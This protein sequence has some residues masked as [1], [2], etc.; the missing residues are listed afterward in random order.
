MSATLCKHR[1]K[2][3][4]LGFNPIIAKSVVLLGIVVGTGTVG[5]IWIEGWS[6]WQSLFFTLITLSTVGYGDNGLSEAGERF[7]AVLMIGGIGTV[8]YTA[9]SLLN[10]AV[11]RAAHPER[12][13]MQRIKHL[14]DHHVVCGLGRTGERVIERLR[15][16]NVEV[17]A[18]DTNSRAVEKMRTRGVMA[19]E[20][21]A[22]LDDTLA[23][24]GVD[25]AC[26]IAVVT[27][28]DAVNALIC[29][30]AR[31]L[32][33]ETTIIA[34]AEDETSVRK[35][36]R[37]GATNVIAPASYGGDGVAQYMLHP[38]VNHLLRG[39]QTEGAAIDFS[40]IFVSQESPHCGRTIEEI[41]GDNPRLVFVAARGRDQLVI[42]RPD[43]MRPLEDGDVLVV[44]GIPED[45]RALRAFKR[46]A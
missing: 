18:I 40:E 14:R 25:R 31:A 46:A 15:E 17:V 34:R 33:P 24:A 38:Q 45:V 23:K 22:S 43:P 11:A 20:G 27:S 1:P 30:T 6:A 41:G 12:R 21:D 32:T 13:I 36:Q 8:S 5:Y 44:A 16:E 10:R 3:T 28:S 9:T 7:T 2:T 37:A 39:L 19:I 29:L 4:F 42:V 26:A 35:L